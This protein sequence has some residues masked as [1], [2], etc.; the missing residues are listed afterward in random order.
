MI[1]TKA[2]LQGA[3]VIDLEKHADTR[4]FFARVFCQHE[5][6]EHDLPRDMVQMNL[7]HSPEKGTL[8]GLHY[9]VAPHEEAKYIRCTRG[10][11][12]DVSVDVRPDSPTFGQWMGVELTQDNYRMVYVPEGCAHGYLTLTADSEVNYQVSSFYTPG[13]ERGIRYD[14]PAIGIEWP[15]EIR[16]V[17]EKDRSWPA[18]EASRRA[19]V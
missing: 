18:F 7:S 17:S 13:V 16:V 14:D 4:G 19:S 10:A 11:V 12:Y 2:A 5:F 8:R 9:Q 3:Y 6:A 15:A 1:F